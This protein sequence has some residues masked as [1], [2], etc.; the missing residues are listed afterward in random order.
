[1]PIQIFE[2]TGTLTS[3]PMT[4]GRSRGW[5]LAVIAGAT[6]GVWTLGLWGCDS[7]TPTAKA[8]EEASRH[9][10]VLT[11][12]GSPAPSLE[13][14]REKFT[15]VTETLRD[16]LDT[17]LP[18]E[19]AAAIVLTAQAKLG[20][21][22]HAAGEAAAAERE[23]LNRATVVRGLLAAWSN[24]SSQAAATEGYDPSAVI[25]SFLKQA[26]E[27]DA[28][29]V[30]AE[31]M[32]LEL[33]AKIAGLRA[34]IKGKSE[35]A[36]AAENT[37]ASL[38]SQA[39][40]VS[41]TAA[42]GLIKQ[43]A[44]SKRAADTSR[45]EAAL[46]TARADQLEPQAREAELQVSQFKN[47]K[48]TLESMAAQLR[49]AF[50]ESKKEA[51]GARSDAAAVAETLDK[52]LS[53]LRAHREDALSKAF[54]SAA[55][56]FTDAAATVRKA[57]GD[58]NGTSKLV[59]GAAKQSAGDLYWAR[60]H[61]QRAYADLLRTLS[62]SKPGLSNR[63]KYLAEAGEV[64]KAMKES[65][66]SAKAAY[67]EARG[68]YTSAKATGEAKEKLQNLGSILERMPELIDGKIPNLAAAMAAIKA[69]QTA[70]D[71]AAAPAA[72]D[73][74]AQAEGGDLASTVDAVLLAMGEKRV[75]DLRGMMHFAAGYEA[76]GDGVVRMGE[77]FSK[78]DTACKA[79][80]GAG[81][82]ELT[83]AL[84]AGATGMR[85][86]Q[87]G[88]EAWV[89]KKASDL[90]VK[91]EG[92]T[93]TATLP[94]TDETMHFVKVAGVWKLDL[95]LEK[96]IPAESMSQAAAMF[97][98]LAEGFESLAAEVDAGRYNTIDAV[99]VGLMQKL[100]AAMGA[101][102]QGGPGGG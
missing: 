51:A 98:P 49:T 44:E 69:S 55:S 77:A 64:E 63:E 27:R 82:E 47:Q 12:S 21:A 15:K 97:G 101:L 45:L 25:E 7:R 68:A 19:R 43:A 81:A 57:T 40:T 59:L 102:Q 99:R 38:K 62:A 4:A 46:V 48:R 89:G 90:D 42:E 41:A 60:A 13:I 34:E 56:Q 5:T 14:E 29:A 17:G 67:E 61:G 22:E 58:D 30:K 100:Q 52:K 53:E 36:A 74:V 96:L 11:T 71:E 1:M 91:S 23:S 20:L 72:T 26:G 31:A 3:T 70:P 8:V 80:F 85:G 93:G 79:K 94:G 88:G 65:A 6:T 35:S 28:E 24:H 2:K 37:Y 9:M 54:D 84:G 95:Q 16:V 83:K 50:E 78:L 66:E 86:M 73:D 75:S 39:V 87:M 10:S 33:S 76:A 18:Q 32:R 92:D